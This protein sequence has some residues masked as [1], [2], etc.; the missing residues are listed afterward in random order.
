MNELVDRQQEVTEA[1]DALSET[2]ELEIRLVKSIT[3]VLRHLALV[4]VEQDR[5][6]AIEDSLRSA[7]HHENVLL[8]I[9]QLVDRQLRRQTTTP[10]TNHQ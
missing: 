1:E 5:R 6:T 8:R 4:S 3:P 7:L 2:S 10:R 9:G